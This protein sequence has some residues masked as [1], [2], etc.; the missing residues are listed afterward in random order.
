MKRILIIFFILIGVYLIYTL[1]QN[2]PLLNDGNYT[3]SPI[4]NSVEEIEIDVA[5]LKLEIIPEKRDNIEVEFEGKGK[6]KLDDKRRKITIEHE[7]PFFNFFSV[8]NRS[9]LTVYIPEDYNRSLAVD[10]GSGS[11]YLS[12][13]SDKPYQL[14]KLSVN[15]SSG[16]AELNHLNVDD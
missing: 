11:L 10:M 3:T 15:M 8:F 1:I 2:F 14:K 16:H 4:S 12:G 13:S 5:S 9:H 6:V 7:Q